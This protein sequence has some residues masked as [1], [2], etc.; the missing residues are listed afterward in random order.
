MHRNASRT[1]LFS[2]ILNSPNYSILWFW[3]SPSPD[4]QSKDARARTKGIN[5]SA[6]TK[7]NS[8][9]TGSTP[10]LLFL[11]SRGKVM[12]GIDGGEW[13]FHGR[14]LML[15]TLAWFWSHFASG[16][17][18][19]TT[20]TAVSSPVQSLCAPSH[21]GF[22]DGRPCVCFYVEHVQ[23]VIVFPVPV[24]HSG[25][26]RCLRF[27]WLLSLWLW[28][29]WHRPCSFATQPSSHSHSDTLL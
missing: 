11:A 7:R 29:W 8:Y 19:I 9:A 18:F 13:D 1:S 6:E 20:H 27:S 26:G 21:K 25:S 2:G 17:S 12:F 15:T 4:V 5:L 16:T 22:T 23:Y 10:P 28:I 24:T 3:I 14:A